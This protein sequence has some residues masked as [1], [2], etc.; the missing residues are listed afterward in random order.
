MLA[1]LAQ[2][3]E[4]QP[5]PVAA[6]PL[7]RGMPQVEAEPFEHA[8]DALFLA[9]GE[10]ADLHRVAAVE[11]DADGHCLAVAQLVIGQ[12]FELVGRPV[13]IVERPGAAALEGIA[14]VRDLPHVQLGAAPDHARHGLRRAGAQ[15]LDLRLQPLEEH[16]VADQPDLDRLGHAGDAIARVQRAQEVGVVE[17]R[18]RRRE[19]ADEVL[20]PERVDAVLHADARVVLRQDRGRHA[21]MAHAAMGGRRDEAHHVEERPAADRDDVGMAV[22]AQ[23]QQAVLQPG[24]QLGVVLDL[25]AADDDLGGREQLQA[26]GVMLGV[27]RDVVRQGGPARRHVRVDED[28][29]PMALVGFLARKRGDEHRIVAREQVVGEVD[30]I[31]VLHREALVVH[32]AELAGFD[33]GSGCG[34]CG[35]FHGCVCSRQDIRRVTQCP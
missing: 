10:H 2:P 9:R 16:G 35:R 6:A 1:E 31:V 28:D 11:R 13:A 17:H 33:V 3:V 34:S 5:A 29:E 27:G 22:D 21:H 8:E 25:L 15:R 24:H 19:G 30:R 26:G 4:H 18:E 12:R 23:L 14:A 32:R 7:Q 20:D